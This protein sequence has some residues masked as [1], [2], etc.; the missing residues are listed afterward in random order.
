MYRRLFVALIL[1][2]SFSLIYANAPSGG[3]NHLLAPTHG[4]DSPDQAA[5]GDTSATVFQTVELIIPQATALHLDLTHV[6]FDL[7]PLDGTGWPHDESPFED[8]TIRC[9]YGLQ[10][11][12][13][14][15]GTAFFGQKEVW[16]LGTRY[17]AATWPNINVIGGPAVTSYPPIRLDKG[18]LIDG[19]KDYF[20][21]YK[22]FIL[23]K[24]SNFK[25]WD[26][27]VYRFPTPEN[28]IGINHMY[29]QDNTCATF[30][31]PTGLYELPT[32]H[33]RRLIPSSLAGGPTGTQT[34]GDHVPAMCKGKS[35][36]DDLV[37][38]A[39]K[40]NADHHGSNV[41]TLAYTLTSSDVKFDDAWRPG[42]PTLPNN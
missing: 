1:I 35:W 11:T 24:F 31:T 28:E 9:V 41:A 26:L 13:Y 39:V 7:T 14:D 30:G 42:I 3:Q 40:I 37:V 22:S 16:P 10:A 20:V 19:S 23:Q 25:Y 2:S 8:N 27:T 38:L 4:P 21:C 6:V 33:Q 18:E 36:L 15:N 5:K 17:A 12:D 32:G 34:T 29:I